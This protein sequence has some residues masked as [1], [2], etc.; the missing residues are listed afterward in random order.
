MPAPVYDIFRKLPDDTPV[1]VEAVEGLEKVKQR[2]I[3]LMSVTPGN[4]LVCDLRLQK[5]IEPFRRSV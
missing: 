3:D 2:L 4:Y 1:W 5:F